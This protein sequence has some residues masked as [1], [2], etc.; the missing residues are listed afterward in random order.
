[1]IHEVQ[2]QERGDRPA[3]SEELRRRLL[4]GLPVAERRLRLAD[5]STAVLEG[6]DGPPLVL[7][8][9]PG[10]SAASF[11]RVVPQ[12]VARHRVV[13]PDLPGHGATDA[14][15]GPL[16]AERVLA[17]LGELV[18][19][20]CQTRPAIVGQTL[21]GAIAARFAIEKRD[22]PGRLVLVDT[23][24]LCPFQ[25]AP[26]FAS[27]LMGYLGD[28]TEET[29]EQLWRRCAF[30]LEAMRERMGE[31]WKRLEAYD[32][33]RARAPGLGPVQHGLMGDF[34][35]PEIPAADLARIAVPVTL[36]WGRQD[37]ATPLAVAQAASARQGWPLH[38]IESSGDAPPMEQ[39]EAFASAL[40]AALSPS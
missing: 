5:I 9:G 31:S 14:G 33:D 30:D 2:H 11:M 35:M 7:L 12:L 16:P 32:L 4:A 40:R 25:P 26:E 19:R 15:D 27:A 3:G 39:P 17:W 8:H 13:I 18:E 6:G 36:I 34:G 10:E 1:M 37:L 24:G 29:H 23:L 20:T 22:R 38:V 21:G 28:P